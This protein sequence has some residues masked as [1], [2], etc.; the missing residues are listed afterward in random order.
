MKIEYGTS[1]FTRTRGNLPPLELVNLFVE[2]GKTGDPVILQSRKGIVPLSTHGNGPVRGVLQREG[3]FD[4]DKFVV[5]GNEFYRG[6]TLLGDIVGDGP[7][8]LSATDLEV[9]VCAGGPLYSYN[10]TDFVEVVFPDDANVTAITHT[11]GYFIALRAGTG[12]WYFSAVLDGRTWDGLDFATAESEPDYLLDAVVL[13]G[14]VVFGG[15]QSVEF[16]AA[17]GDKDLP[18][19][20]IQQREFEQGVAATG[21]MIV[22]DNTVYFLG[23]DLILYRS[24][25]VPQAVSDDGV[26]EA[27]QASANHRLFVVIDERHK[28]ICLRLDNKTYAYDVTTQQTC[29]F[30]SYGRSNWRVGPGMGDD[31]TGTVWGFD[32]YLDNG[33]TLERTFTAGAVLEGPVIFNNLRL[34]AEVGTTQYLSGEYASPKIEMRSSD[35]GGNIWDDWE[36]EE[37]GE[38]GDYSKRVEWRHLGMFAD[39]GALFQFRVSDPVSVRFS[40]VQANAPVGGR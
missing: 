27:S 30:T 33:G 4:G 37:L 35:D 18:F 7:V 38:Q 25:E 6:S 10:G 15:T 11:A 32:G 3:V 31:E 20:Q 21:C 12:R 1:A 19:S 24:G 17:T 29:E 5:S 23:A 28:F 2:A 9:L 14:V 26:V 34:S 16:W 39:P 36:I 13:D 22:L 8:S 40:N